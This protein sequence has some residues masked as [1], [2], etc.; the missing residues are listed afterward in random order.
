M[1]LRDEITPYV[2]GN[3]FV[4]PG[5]VPSGQM[6]GS[7][8]GLCFTAE[9]L[10]TLKKRQE[11]LPSDAEQWRKLF[12]SCE[13]EP[14]LF[15]RAPRD[16]DPEA[17][18]DFY[19]V[20]AACAVLDTPEIAQRILDY[21]WQHRGDYDNTQPGSFTWS[22]FLWRQPQLLAALYAAAKRGRWNPFVWV[23]NAVAAAVIASSCIGVPTT[24]TDERRLAWLLIQTLAPV[25]RPC[26]LAA[27]AWFRRL[28]KDYPGLLRDGSVKGDGGMRAVAKIYYQ[29]GHPLAKYYMNAEARG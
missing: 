25:S 3:G 12:A 20:A 19:G 18:D 6:Q 14:G 8:N 16:G 15:D 11:G 22:S 17:P 13:I 24:K 26:R 7:D 28:K 27:R 1:S 5:R 29:L 2:D 10:I 4:S 21:G 23:L 9:F